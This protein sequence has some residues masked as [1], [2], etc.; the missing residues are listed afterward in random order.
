V[1]YGASLQVR[2]AEG[3]AS[4]KSLEGALEVERVGGH[5]NLRS[6]AGAIIE[7]VE[8]HLSARNVAGDLRLG[9][10][11]GNAS[12]RDIQGDLAAEAIDGNL[13][14]EDL[15]GEATVRVRGNARLSLD[16]LPGQRF[17]CNAD[18]N[19]V[20]RL[21]QSASARVEVDRAAS[22]RVKLPGQEPKNIAAPYQL[23]LGE[24]GAEVRL[25]AGGNVLISE[26]PPEFGFEAGTQFG[27][28]EMAASIERQV[29]LQLESQLEMLEGQ[30][31]DLSVML[32]TASLPHEQA[33]RIQR[34]AREAGE[35]AAARAREKMRRAQERM[36]RK[37]EEA[38]RR[39]ELKSRAAEWAG[40]DRRRR[41]QPVEAAPTRAGPAAGRV[42][43]QERL[44]VLR[45]LQEGKITAEQ[46][47]Q[48]LAALEGRSGT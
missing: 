46:A 27:F 19:L 12:V 2:R 16:P 38:Q 5:L 33:E 1:P 22:V 23:M 39:A 11:G 17:D 37:L 9:R 44:A 32:S 45:M 3:H 40:R 29:E 48:L 31:D 18:G 7:R 20:C 4:I 28:E 41:P 36:Q 10:V 24:G 34:R 21:P 26:Q 15:D 25:Q 47:E 42:N 8:G 30:L 6:V 14:L 43:E 13:Q 35:R